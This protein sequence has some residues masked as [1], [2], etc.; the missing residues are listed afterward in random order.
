MGSIASITILGE[1]KLAYKAATALNAVGIITVAPSGDSPVDCPENTL[2]QGG[3]CVGAHEY[4]QCSC[5]KKIWPNSG[6]GNCVET[7]APGV[8]ILSASNT[9]NDGK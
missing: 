1:S 9:D 3:L 7:I 8:N 2:C 6:Y 5:K 4:E